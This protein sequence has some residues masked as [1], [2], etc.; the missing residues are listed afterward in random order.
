MRTIL[1]F[2]AG[3]AFALLA[4]A[5]WSGCD[6]SNDP[7]APIQSGSYALVEPDPTPYVGYT[8]TVSADLTTVREAYTRSGV[9]H[10]TIYSVVERNP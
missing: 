10:E 9:A 8:L 4:G 1:S 5:A 3:A 7:V 6:C 2:V